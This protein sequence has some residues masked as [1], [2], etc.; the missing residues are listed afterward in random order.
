ML[1]PGAS[2]R[3]PCLLPSRPSCAESGA[4][5][6]DSWYSTSLVSRRHTRRKSEALFRKPLLSQCE[7]AFGAD[8][9]GFRRKRL[10][11]HLHPPIGSRAQERSL[12]RLRR[13]VPR[14]PAQDSSV[15]GAR[16]RPPIFRSQSRCC[17]G[18]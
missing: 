14:C 13:V 5:F 6:L 17:D 4:A 7:K 8:C 9:P 2:D 16:G 11:L 15:L 18:G 12:R 1:I 10:G 3:F